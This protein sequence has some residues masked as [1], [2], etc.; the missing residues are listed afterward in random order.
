MITKFGNLVVGDEIYLKEN[1]INVPYIVVHQGKPDVMAY[2]NSCMGTWLLRKH[3]DDDCTWSK[4]CF[5]NYA[6]SDIHEWLNN[7]FFNRFDCETQEVMNTVNLPYMPSSKSPFA[8]RSPRIGTVICKIF[9]LSSYEVGRSSFKNKLEYFIMG[10]EEGYKERR[11]A[12]TA[13]GNI[14][15]WHLRYP[16]YDNST[17][18]ELID[19]AGSYRYGRA[20]ATRGVRPAMIVNSEALYRGDLCKS[21]I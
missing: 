19:E 1:G 18:V 8:D 9:L 15:Q 20:Y 12:T 4:E 5:N 3:A 17:D 10:T 21:T 13:A 2:D 6:K 14:I 16:Y 11:I 7:T